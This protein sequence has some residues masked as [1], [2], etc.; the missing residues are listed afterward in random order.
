[1]AQGNSA[2][3]CYNAGEKR[4]DADMTI[5]G[6]FVLV[7]LALCMSLPTQAAGKHAVTVAV[8]GTPLI[9]PDRYVLMVGQGSVTAMPDTAIVSGGVVTKARTAG[10][11]LHDNN[12]AM[13]KVVAALKA[14]GITDKQIATSRIQFQPVYPPYDPKTGQSTKVIGYQV[15]NSVRVTLSDLSRAGDVL[16]A[17]I[18]NGAN[19]SATIDFEIKD[20]AALE[21]KA[22][23]EASKDALRRALAYANQVG[24]ELGPVRSIREGDH[25]D[26]TVAAEDIG[27]LPDRANG[28]ALQRIPGV[29]LTRVEAGEQTISSTVTVVW[30]LK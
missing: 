6:S 14:L 18:E 7:A 24:A 16:Y 23:T 26:A 11:A 20:R 13:A 25:S 19:D 15:S 3:F 10:D 4:G 8:E 30:A 27:A 17:L 1:V 5:R 28:E 2:E 9:A 22:R 12:E 21:E 29:A